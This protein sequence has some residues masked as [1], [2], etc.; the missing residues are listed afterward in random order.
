M[1]G[2]KSRKQVQRLV[3]EKVG[4]SFFNPNEEGKHMVREVG[5]STDLS[6][7]VQ[8]L[9]KKETR[10]PAGCRKGKRNLNGGKKVR[11]ALEEGRSLKAVGIDNAV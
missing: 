6:V 3:L 2:I 9:V 1:E 10:S 8:F 11:K 7:P 4:T 5:M